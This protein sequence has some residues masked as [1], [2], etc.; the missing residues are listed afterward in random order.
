M[1]RRWRHQGSRKFGVCSLGYVVRRCSA[2]GHT[3]MAWTVVRRNIVE[4][5][6][7]MWGFVSWTMGIASCLSLLDSIFGEERVQRRHHAEKRAMQ[8]ALGMTWVLHL[9]FQGF[10]GSDVNTLQ[11]VF[12]VLQPYFLGRCFGFHVKLL[13]KLRYV[14]RVHFDVCLLWLHELWLSSGKSTQNHRSCCLYMVSLIF[15]K[16]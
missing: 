9:I 5:C 16:I 8:Q 10:S 1:R 2:S 6:R 12:W 4:Y 11:R 3:Q 14:S 13:C 7:P 15:L